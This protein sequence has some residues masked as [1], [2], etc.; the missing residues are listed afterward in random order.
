MNSSLISVSQP[1]GQEMTSVYNMVLSVIIFSTQTLTIAF[2]CSELLCLK[3][4]QIEFKSKH[5]IHL[6]YLKHENHRCTL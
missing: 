4:Y 2:V 6:I 5:K 1:A 3:I